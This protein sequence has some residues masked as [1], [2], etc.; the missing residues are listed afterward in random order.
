MKQMIFLKWEIKSKAVWVSAI[1]SMPP[2]S[3]TDSVLQQQ[4]PTHAPFLGLPGY[5]HFLWI[6]ITQVPSPPLKAVLLRLEN[7]VSVPLDPS[8]PYSEAGPAVPVS[9]AA[10]V[11]SVS[12]FLIFY[13]MESH[14]MR[15]CTNRRGNNMRRNRNAQQHL[16]AVTD[17][18][19]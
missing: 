7:P 12:L 2:Y 3:T 13:T 5:C 16:L 19:C 14:I 15:P 8:A 9:L 6:R 4:D 17:H 11:A 18:G 10:S 1:S